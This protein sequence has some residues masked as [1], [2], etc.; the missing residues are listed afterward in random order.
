MLSHCLLALIVSDE[1][2]VIYLIGVLL[3]AKNLLSVAQDFI[4]G[5]Q[6]SCFMSE[7]G[8]SVLFSYLQFVEL[9]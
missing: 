5:F 7:C 6:Y 2:S 8:F 3:Y 4:F 9:L 1:K